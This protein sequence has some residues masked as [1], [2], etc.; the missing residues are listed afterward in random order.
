MNRKVVLG[1]SD[2]V[3]SAVAAKVLKESGYEVYGLYLDISGENAKKDAMAS[4]DRLGIPLTVR[5]I[6]AELD[7]YVCKPFLNAYLAGETPNPCIGCNRDVKFPALIGHADAVGAELIA[8]GHYA[9]VIGN[10]IYTGAPDNDQSYMLTRLT[11]AQIE[12][13]I[14]PLGGFE[15]SRVREMA[16]EMGLSVAN[17]PDSREICFIPDKNYAEWLEERADVPGGGDAIFGGK[18]V[19]KHEGIHKYTVGQRFGETDTGRRMYV[20]GIDAENNALMLSLWDDL[21]KTEF[22][23]RDIY[24]QAE[25]DPKEIQAVVR[26]RHTRWEMPECTVKKEGGRWLVRTKTPVRAPAR[27]QTAAF[28]HGEKLLGGGF[29][30]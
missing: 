21:F 6:K 25:D 3:D 28:Y 9:R 24:W 13:L 5:D 4:A 26:V 18:A 1:L 7:T 15:K 17:K 29:I 11:K 23:V 20:S 14:L 19:L 8:T 22:Y 10:S 30:D 16:R 2:G 27:G 12:R